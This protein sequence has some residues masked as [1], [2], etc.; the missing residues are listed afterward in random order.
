MGAAMFRLGLVSFFVMVGAV[1]LAQAQQSLQPQTQQTPAVES[2]VPPAVT[3][4]GPPPPAQ[5][6]TAPITASASLTGVSGP[7]LVSRDG[8]G[9]ET[10][11]GDTPLNVGDRVM[12]EEGGE[13]SLLLGDCEY[14]LVE[15]SL[16]TIEQEG[17]LLVAYATLEPGI[18]PAAFPILPA[19]AGT[20]AAAGGA[21]LAATGAGDQGTASD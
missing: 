11:E 4:E 17:E 3:E 10:A 21:A 9:F 14:E 20:T 12:V 6:C 1:P 13:A 2:S 19:V 7:V 18:I 5:V 15:G 8:G 16:V